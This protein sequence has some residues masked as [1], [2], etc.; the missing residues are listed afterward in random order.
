MRRVGARA[1]DSD[2]PYE[3]GLWRRSE[4]G[5]ASV[6]FEALRRAR[7][8]RG[9]RRDPG[10]LDRDEAARLDDSRSSE[11]YPLRLDARRAVETLTAQVSWRP[12]RCVRDALRRQS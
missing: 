11:A 10:G 12:I 5:G 7:T 3:S 6:R 2:I 4:E 9:D 1:R 8:V